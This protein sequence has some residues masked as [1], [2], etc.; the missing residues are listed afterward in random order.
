MSIDP[1]AAPKSHV[2]D[3]PSRSEN[4]IAEGR[5]ASSGWSWVTEAWALVKPNLGTWIGLFLVFVVIVIVLSFIPF[6]GP[7]ALNIISPI[8]LGGV[9]L[10]CDALRR[11]E[12]LTVGHLFAGF[13]K[14]AGKLAGVG[15]FLVLGY[16][17]IFAILAVIFGAAIAGMFMGGT[18]DPAAAAAMGMT[19]L[20]AV[21]IMMALSIPLYMAVWFSYPLIAL[22]DFTV[23][24]ALRTS[25][26]ACLK[27]IVPVLVYGI[28]VFVLAILA[29]IPLG[30]GWLLLGP[31]ALASLYTSYRDI[32]YSA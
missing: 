12:P 15:A 24:Q 25:F 18:S 11:G 4:F 23:G 2:A 16:I 9:M 29:S 30:L 19:M 17:A 20:L 5:A 31:V 27:N 22:N 26:F 6:L 13:S 14:N 3:T 32:F 8:L 10:G 21:L 28:V 1:Y 7:L